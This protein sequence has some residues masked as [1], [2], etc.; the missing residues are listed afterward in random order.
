MARLKI[1]ASG[2][3]RHARAQARVKL[4]QGLVYQVLHH[5]GYAVQRLFHANTPEMEIEVEG[6][7]TATNAP[8][9][10]DCRFCE[11]P[12]SAS[13]L[14]AFYGKYMARWHRD[15][16]CHGLFLALPGIDPAARDFYRD[17][18]AE[19]SDVTAVL[20]EEDAV[21]KAVSGS[22]GTS[23]QDVLAKRV[24]RNMGIPGD[25]FLF[26]TEKGVF[27]AWMIIAKGKENRNRFAL[28]DKTGSLVSDPS[29]RA[30]LA[31]LYPKL[32]DFDP[33]VREETVG[34]QPGLFQDADEIVEV[35]GGP[36]CFEYQCPAS[37]GDFVGRKPLL[38]ALDA[39]VEKVTHKETSRRGILF[40]GFS[41]WGKSSLV[42][43][44]VARLEK[45]G[46]FAVAIDSRTAASSN[47]IPCL[48]HHT[49]EKFGDFGGLF[50]QKDGFQ[51]T[52]GEDPGIGSFLEMG[53]VLESGGKLLFIVLDSFDPGFFQSEVIDAIKD[54]FLGICREQTNIVFGFSWNT[55]LVSAVRGFNTALGDAVTDNSEKMILSRFSG[56][57]TNALLKK[58]SNE[59]NEPLIED[60]RWFLM[61]FS[62]GYPWLLKMLCFHVKTARQSGIPLELIAENLLSVEELFQHDI[63]KLSDKGRLSLGHIAKFAPMRP[64]ESPGMLDAHVVQNLIDQKVVQQIGSTVDV[65]GEVFR[66]FLNTGILPFLDD[67]ILGAGVGDVVNAARVLHAA[68][69]RLYIPE[70]RE[71][72]GLPGA[73][74]YRVAKDMD[75]LGVVRFSK[76]TASL[77]IALPAGHHDIEASL[78]KHLR[79]RLRGSRLVQSLLKILEERN[80]LALD[81]V[82]AL[83]EISAPHRSLA[84]KAGLK[85]ARILAEWID[86]ADLAV[87]NKKKRMLVF[88]DPATEIRERSLLLPKRRGSKIPQ[89]Q[90][91]QIEKMAE[92]IFQA[93]QGDGRVDWTGFGKNA[94]FRALATLEDL[95]FIVRRAPL[96]KMLPKGKE[97]VQ[98]MDRRPALF[99]EGALQMP[100]FPI[101]IE[102][103]ESHRFKGNTLLGLGLVLKERLG[104]NWKDNTAET[105]AQIMLDWARHAKLAPGVFARIRRG[106]IK[107][108]KKKDDGQI[109]LF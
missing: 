85:Y 48:I 77:E 88:F 10:A 16:R 15:K 24:F 7:H 93:L 64:T 59:L 25:S 39:F 70:L 104:T 23:G 54:L 58:L 66:T 105:I 41:G 13:H 6:T 101:F 78:R 37:P 75:L 49:L 74:F 40:E 108:W 20:Y 53:K 43:S 76:G 18:I 67:P 8:F 17:Y 30:Y 65:S 71:Q 32:A 46:H 92:R 35:R 91:S 28:F 33:I 103:L 5:Y 61:E 82:S 99:A 57:E 44:S 72:T 50:P 89:I 90:Y 79:D 12:V 36:E 22:P 68:G 47:F 4:F 97:F 2:S 3:T 45:M 34:L 80:T 102:I 87:W 60:L 69:G 106:P 29:V 107:G 31:E 19:I 51:W 38:K 9:Y 11:T 1:L 86:F 81:D 27:R 62:Q 84:G 100:S 95:G 42:L 63:E 94:I 109:T 73:L 56:V 83:F 55:D 14:Q 26:Y 21:V 52:A 98:N 96:I